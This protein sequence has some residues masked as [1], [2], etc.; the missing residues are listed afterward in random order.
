M[1]I[2][3]SLSTT[4]P[5][6]PVKA[7]NEQPGPS[8][9]SVASVENPSGAQGPETQDAA[10]INQSSGSPTKQPEILF[11][12]QGKPVS[13]EET[14]FTAWVKL[15]QE[16]PQ[17]PTGIV[18]HYELFKKHEGKFPKWLVKE[19]KALFFASNE[20]SQVMLHFNYYT[21]HLEHWYSLE[22]SGPENIL[23]YFQSRIDKIAK[24]NALDAMEYIFC[25]AHGGK[26]HL[27]PEAYE[28]ALETCKD[29]EGAHMVCRCLVYQYGISNN[30]S[31]ANL[32][33]EGCRKY[34]LEGYTAL[35]NGTHADLKSEL[36]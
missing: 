17:P 5:S 27:L 10:G 36:E 1:A 13:P 11:A 8:A 3:N 9:V 33:L 14:I 25:F 21:K 30:Q 26:R 18:R 7:D 20:G 29:L 6:S 24:T 4:P 22:A 35:V 31:Y 34:G 2:P 28:K 12:I 19:A 15:A 16:K 32:G 23:T